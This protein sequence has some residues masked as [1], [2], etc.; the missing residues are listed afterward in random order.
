[1][2]QVVASDAQHGTVYE[3][4]YYHQL[5]GEAA[6]GS[7]LVV[8]EDG[9]GKWRLVS[10]LLG[11]YWAD[12]GWMDDTKVETT[13]TNRANE[14]VVLTETVIGVQHGAAVA[15]QWCSQRSYA[16]QLPLRK[17]RHERYYVKVLK[18]NTFSGIVKQMVEDDGCGDRGIARK[19]VGSL[20]KE[21]RQMNVG[22]DIGHLAVGQEIAIPDGERRR[23]IKDARAG[24]K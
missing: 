18:G 19:V 1:W 17:A 5:M 11:N 21:I 14:P 4:E 3:V 9:Q 13:W 15:L 2:W 10:L 7:R 8:W 6:R 24:Q 22:L 16:G 12:T 20:S 23:A